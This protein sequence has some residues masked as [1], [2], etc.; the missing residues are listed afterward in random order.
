MAS[1]SKR[2]DYQYQVI[3]RRKG[4]PSQTRTF[5]TR[6]QAQEWAR[7]VES[8]MDEGRFR[9]R[10]GL[11][12]ITLHKALA[13]YAEKVSPQKAGCATELRRISQLQRHPIAKRDMGSLL[14]RD[15]TAYRDQRMKEVGPSTVRLELA[16]LSH[17]YTIAIKEWSWPLTHE[18]QN[19]RK[20]P[21]PQGRERRLVGD[22]KERLLAAIQRPQ[23]RSALWL[24][25]CVR[26]AIETGMRAGELLSLQWHQVNIASGVIRLEKTKNGKRR[27]VP[28]TEEAVEM[29]DRLPRTGARVIA[30]YYDTPGLDRAFK[31]AC[32]AAGI[33]GLRFHD[34]RH[35]A[36]TDYAPHMKAQQ[37]A[38]IMGWK[39][40]GM[41]MRYYN[42][43]DAELVQLVR[44]SKLA[45]NADIADRAKAL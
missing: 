11:A 2:G 28:L 18:V 37:L 39:T 26:L 24:D 42:P 30:G 34:L 36:A 8:K 12:S 21:A 23:A 20:P 19:V 14:A 40:L 10:R 38:K 5:E 22:E 41:T 43:T 44:R 16:L 35:Q 45:A 7:S 32:T 29:L 15:F 27:T 9:D 25:A 4:H 33:D 31:R 1:I 17:L 6:A 13:L 3:V